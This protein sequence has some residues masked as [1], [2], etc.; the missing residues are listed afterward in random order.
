MNCSEEV[1]SICPAYPS[2]GANCWKTLSTKCAGGQIELSSI[3]EKVAFC[4]TC[5][6]YIHN[7][8]NNAIPSP[9]HNNSVSEL[10]DKPVL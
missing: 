4:R 8:K 7:V 1:R 5:E 9:Y 2:D 3:T 6:F 10:A